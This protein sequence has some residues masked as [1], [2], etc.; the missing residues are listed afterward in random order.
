MKT[1]MCLLL[2]LFISCSSIP[3]KSKGNLH[4]GVV[5]FRVNGGANLTDHMKRIDEFA[6]KAKSKNASFILLPELMILDLLP[7]NPSEDKMHEFLDQLAQVA[8]EYEKNLVEISLIRKI[9][10]IGASVVIK[11]KDHYINRAFYIT[12]EGKVSYQDKV[13]PTPWEV[14]HGFRGGKGISSFKS[15]DFSFAI[16]ICHDSEF[17]NLSASLIRN[18]PEVIFVPSQT[19]DKYGLNRVKY[20]SSARS[21]EHMAYVLMTGTSGDPKAV[22]HSYV[23]QNFFFP[24]QNKYFSEGYQNGSLNKESLSLYSLDIETL[25]KAREDLKQVYPARDI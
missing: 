22:W 8:K 6:K 1:I 2:L 15:K 19:D 23:G 24:P 13:K 21:I 20:S 25:R 17:P 3:A 7:L 11:E 9:N 12:E 10:I 5:N 4:I 14:R 16:M 18:K